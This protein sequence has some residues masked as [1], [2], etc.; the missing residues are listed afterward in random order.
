MVVHSLWIGNRLGEVHAAC[1]RSFVR[2]GYEVILHS[3]CKPDDTPSG[4]KIFDAN[5]LMRE[6]EIIRHQSGSL[7]LASDIYRYRIQREGLGL[8]VDCDVY[9]LKPFEDSDYVLGWE[10]HKT[11]NG[12]VL[13]VPQDSEMLKKMLEAS[14]NPYF[15]PPWLSMR[16]TR[17]A[18]LKKLVGRPKHISNQHWGAIGPLLITHLVSEL[19][20][21]SRVSSIDTYYPLHHHHTPLLFQAGLR[22][23]DLVTPRTVAVHL[24]NASMN[25]RHVIEGSPIHEIISK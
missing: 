8:Y 10:D 18:K 7:A 24:F 6:D 3:Y 13:K 12:A 19:G 25:N 22:V 9:C 15:I 23:E 11:V 1:L 5:K 14:E 20:L 17:I 16:K 4:V 21:G 2:N